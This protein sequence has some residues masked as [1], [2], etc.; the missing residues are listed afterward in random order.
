[1]R[2]VLSDEYESVAGLGPDR[3]IPAS[4]QRWSGAVL[5]LA[6]VGAMGLWAYRLGTQDA[7]E[8][9]VIKAM[10]GP[11]RVAPQDPGGR[12]AAHQGLEVNAVLAGK[13][14]S[15]QKEAKAARPEPAALT[16]ED[17]PQADLEL[18]AAPPPAPP[19]DL[20]VSADAAP[21]AA[22]VNIQT[23]L[24]AM[25]EAAAP[26]GSEPP[27]DAQAAAEAVR[28]KLRPANLPAVKPKPVAPAP[29]ATAALA[30]TPAAAAPPTAPQGQLPAGTRLVQLGAYDNEAIARQAWSQLVASQGDL[31]GSKS[32]YLERATSNARVFYRLRVAGFQTAD[33]TRATCEA[34]RAR[35]IDCIPVTLQ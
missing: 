2:D 3:L 34:L 30:S 8:V 26:A 19:A 25:V 24:A 10:A 12:E 13:T 6:L 11:T 21:T 17:A 15:V 35:G 20:P 18:Q 1:M 16:K 5:F 33:Q 32:L 27:A 28:P 31:L 4:V 9:P 7:A 29:I 23:E 22:P 14:I